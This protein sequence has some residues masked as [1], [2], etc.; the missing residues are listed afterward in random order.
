MSGT[1]WRHD[2]VALYYGHAHQLGWMLDA[3]RHGKTW[4]NRNADERLQQRRPRAP[5]LENMLRDSGLQYRLPQLRD[6]IQHGVPEEYR[7]LILPACLCLSKAEAACHSH[8]LQNAAAGHRGL[9]AGPLGP[10]GKGR[11]SGGVLDDLFGVPH[12]AKLRAAD[13]FG[14]SS[15]FE[16][17]P[18]CELLMEDL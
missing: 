17:E 14:A 6:V 2:G 8:L 16:V 1:E 7:V 13:V 10:H 3:Q 15:G 18:G 11:T 12:D 5:R 9:S 4:I